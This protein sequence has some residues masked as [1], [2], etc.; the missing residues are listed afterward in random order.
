MAV[1]V[2]VGMKRLLCQVFCIILHPRTVSRDLEY[3]QICCSHDQTKGL[4][5]VARVLVP[6]T[7]YC[8]GAAGATLMPSGYNLNPPKKSSLLTDSIPTLV[9]LTDDGG[10][11]S[12]RN[13]TREP[14]NI[15]QDAASW[16]LTLPP[17][18]SSMHSLY[19]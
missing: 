7:L 12:C 19:S 17:L 18:A 6:A 5:A 3:A 10:G 13:E 9:L 2:R 4:I 14:A 16:R 1:V 11:C 8:V 15:K